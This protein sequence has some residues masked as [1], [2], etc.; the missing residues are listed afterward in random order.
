MGLVLRRIAWEQRV[1]LPLILCFSV[2]WGF[3]VVAFYAY[4]DARTRDVGL[5][6]DQVRAAL[7]IL[8]IDPLAAW[9]GTAQE[10]PLFIAA[11]LTFVAGSGV[12]AVAGEL[13]GGTLELTLTRPLARSR[14][15]AAYCVALVAGAVAIALAYGVGC[16]AAWLGFRPRPGTLSALPIAEMSAYTALMLVAL[17]AVSLLCSALASERGRALSWLV[18]IVIVSY[19]WFFLASLVAALQP[20]ARISP[21]WW[22]TPSAVVQGSG[23]PWSSIAVLAAVTLVCASASFAQLGRRD[24]A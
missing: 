24:L 2:L 3:L 17:G 20:F 22:Y 13:E 8:G 9:V 14:H 11:A 1:R 15:L 23:L 6:S 18:G 4:A 7:Q 21:W 16:Y 19:A 10:H 5:G 12:R